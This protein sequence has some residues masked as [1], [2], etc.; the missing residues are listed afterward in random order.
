MS[1]ARLNLQV[2]TKPNKSAVA[3]PIEKILFRKQKVL[4]NEVFRKTYVKKNI[5]KKVL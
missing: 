4:L 5:A 2:K 1:K 3:R